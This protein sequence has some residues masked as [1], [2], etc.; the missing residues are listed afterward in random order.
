MFGEYVET[1]NGYFWTWGPQPA[2]WGVEA[3]KQCKWV[4]TNF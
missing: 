3:E 1:S 2:I 4:E